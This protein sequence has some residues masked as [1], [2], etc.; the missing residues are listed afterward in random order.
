MANSEAGGTAQLN[1]VAAKKTNSQVGRPGQLSLADSKAGRSLVDKATGLR[2]TSLARLEEMA[3][4]GVKP[5]STEFER[6]RVNGLNL[7]VSILP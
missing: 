1:L 6:Q 3:P 7:E 2:M 4:Q 5:R